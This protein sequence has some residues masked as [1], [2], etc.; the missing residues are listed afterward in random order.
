[1]DLAPGGRHRR[2]DIEGT[3]CTASIRRLRHLCGWRKSRAFGRR[4]D[5]QR[6]SICGGRRIWNVNQTSKISRGLRTTAGS[7]RMS[8]GGKSPRPLAML[9]SEVGTDDGVQQPERV[10]EMP[11]H[12]FQRAS[13]IDLLPGQSV[14]S[15]ISRASPA[16][17]I[18]RAF[19]A[20]ILFAPLVRRTKSLDVPAF[21]AHR[22]PVDHPGA[23]WNVEPARIV[24]RIDFP[25]K[26]SAGWLHR[27]S[28]MSMP[29]SSRS[30]RAR[31]HPLPP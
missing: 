16:R 23:R 4:P 24:T 13:T 9:F 21:S 20:Q 22:R 7:L 2:N 15:L 17:Q 27:W 10:S 28:D 1:M 8:I 25:C 30:H 29:A 18:H 31:P 14:P 3:G 5:R 12:F 19:R 26:S 11:R 6:W